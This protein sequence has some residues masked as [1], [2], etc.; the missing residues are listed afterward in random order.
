VQ[1]QGLDALLRAMIVDDI[2]AHR[3]LVRVALECSGRFEVVAEASDGREALALVRVHRPDVMLLDVS[4][5]VEDG[6]SAL[7]KIVAAAP[8]TSVVMLS[9]MDPHRLEP[10]ALQKGAARYISKTMETDLLVAAVL[11]VCAARAA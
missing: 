4:M 6:M 11:E 7:P 2:A 1:S 10:L 5:P 3:E 9:S 8:E